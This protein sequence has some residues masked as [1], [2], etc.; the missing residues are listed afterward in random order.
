M[1]MSSHIRRFVSLVGVLATLMVGEATAD[2]RLNVVATLPAHASIAKAV[3]GEHVTVKAL[4]SHNQDAHYVDPRPSFLVPLSR[5]DLLIVNGLELEV[6]WLPALLTNAR[7][8]RIQ[9][10]AAGDFDASKHVK[11]RGAVAGKLSRAQG[12]VH[13]GGNPHYMTD[14]RAAAHVALALGNRLG[15]LRPDLAAHFAASAQRVAA[16]LGDHA[17]ATRKRLA[18]LPDHQRRVV[19]YHDSTVYLCDWLG[20]DEVGFVESKP[21][22]APSPGQAAAVLV[23]IRK[24]GVRVLLQEAY[25]PTGV[26]KRL[27]KL[28]PAKPL[29][30]ASTTTT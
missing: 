22:I 23:L 12:D 13:P 6:G 26:S 28:A 15:E 18:K 29:A 14:P 4:A 20:L 9:V 10:G 24:T 25:Y 2:A 11:R 5:A 8:A 19:A 17:V 3:G 16:S 7:N 27:A 1:P 30:T 21:G